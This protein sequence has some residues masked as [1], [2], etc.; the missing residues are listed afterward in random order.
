M[1]DQGT[2]ITVYRT[3]IRKCNSSPLYLVAPFIQHDML[4]IS[5]YCPLSSTFML[6]LKDNKLRLKAYHVG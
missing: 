4:L 1:L 6:S 5:I 3:V 2:A